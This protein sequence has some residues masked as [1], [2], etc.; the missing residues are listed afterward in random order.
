MEEINS[1]TDLII[2]ETKNKIWSFILNFIFKP[3]LG[4]I[5][6]FIFFLS[7]LVVTKFLGCCVGTI[8]KF[9]IELE[10]YYLALLGFVLVFLIKVLENFRGKEN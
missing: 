7:V 2:A 4:G 9:N 8:E 6:G 5:W 3:A 10:D 1:R